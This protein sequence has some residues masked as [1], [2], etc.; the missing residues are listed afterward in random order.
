MFCA[1]G[2]KTQFIG[3]CEKI[4]KKFLKKIA[5]MPYLAYFSKKFKKPCVNFS[6][7]WTK[8]QFLG[9]F[10]KLFEEFQ[11]NIA[12]NI[13]LAYFSKDLTNHELDFCAF[14]RKT[15]SVGKF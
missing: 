5:K 13:N 7:A 8:A 3:N 10:A 12:K 6:R 9:I 15:Q 1:F 11:R 4:F 2:R 14:R